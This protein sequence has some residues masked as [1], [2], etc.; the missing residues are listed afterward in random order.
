MWQPNINRNLSLKESRKQQAKIKKMQQE[1]KNEQIKQEKK[2]LLSMH[3][4]WNNASL[5]KEHGYLTGKALSITEHDNLRLDND[6]NILC[7]IRLITGELIS[8]QTI[9]FK[10][11]KKFHWKLS[12]KNGFHTFGSL[13][14]SD[15][16]YFAEGIATALSI[17][18]C[19]DK[20]VICVYGKNFNNIAPIIAKAYP[21]KQFIYCCDL[22]LSSDE[23][24]TSE[25]NAK[26]AIALI[27]GIICLPNFLDI[28]ND[29]RP[30]IQRS[31]YNDL[32]V[33]LL[34]QGFERTAALGEVRQQ[35]INKINSSEE[36][37]SEDTTKRKQNQTES[38][39]SPKMS[40]VLLQLIDQE[41]YE[42]FHDEHQDTFCKYPSQKSNVYETRRLAD[43]KFK[44]YLSFIYRRAEGKTISDPALKEALAEMEGRAL[45]DSGSKQQRVFLR[46]GQ[47]DE[48]IYIDLCDEYWQ[49]IEISKSGWKLLDSKEVPVRFERPQH[50]LPLP[51]PSNVE[52]GDISKLWD[53]VNIPKDDQILVLAYM[54][55]CFRSDTAF[56][57]LVILGLQD[58]GKSATQNT[59]R[60]LI[61][62]SSS[63]LRTPPRKGDDLVTEAHC[64][65]LVSY[66]N[67]SWLSDDMHDD[68]C[69][70]S[71][72]SG[73]ATRKFHTNTQ[74]VVV[75]IARP[76]VINGIYNFIRR[77]DLLDR[78]IILEL[79][80][81]D[82]SKR[83]T[84]S[85][86]NKAV[87]ANRGIIF[88]GMLDLFVKV[89]AILPTIKLDRQPRMADFALLGISVEQA[90]ELPQNTFIN[91]YRANR[92]DAKEGA[93]ESSSVMLALV[94]YIEEQP[95]KFWRG[96]PSDLLEALTKFRNPSNHTIWPKSAHAMGGDLKRY[97]A[98]L[99]GVGI[100][101]ISESKKGNKKNK[102]GNFYRISK[103]TEAVKTRP[104]S[105]PNPPTND[106]QNNYD[107]LHPSEHI[108]PVDIT[109][110]KS[111]Q[112]S[113]SQA[114]QDSAPAKV[115]EAD[116]DL[117][118]MV[119]LKTKYGAFI[120][121]EKNRILI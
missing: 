85:Q 58:S 23:R 33:L 49:A 47:L 57:I 60:G 95:G 97:M 93:L 19:T 48:K 118:D 107:T 104:E 6:G 116:L 77:P 32:L 117:V 119:D 35:I 25:Q 94:D 112:D 40:E 7:P 84:D 81:V 61:D 36:I 121:T 41:E 82:E 18:D 31:D 74:Q 14:D 62:P 102:A 17:R 28:P 46:V 115:P 27:G 52:A 43:S 68:L 69:C 106:T 92:A 21:S 50:A 89:L 113:L 13:N 8:T 70:V 91:R 114:H 26:Q 24:M 80:S 15:E 86:L 63:N 108:E 98:S 51:N 110:M 11:K 79:S 111:T 30:E 73:F 65:W 16:I 101:I 38:D 72:G 67:A 12:P 83:K 90:L 96:R 78:A 64:N 75:N 105:P 42:F 5:C 39:K 29:L 20:A 4:Q 88:R 71:T 10:G 9:P 100:E 2:A 53:I 109:T 34:A 45:H 1:Y 56:P 66:N 44:S 87:Q 76:V 120:D 54:L 55:E 22:P 99:Q 59:L 103:I 3:A 37:M